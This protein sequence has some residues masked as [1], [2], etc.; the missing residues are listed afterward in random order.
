MA[1]LPLDEA[2]EQGL[3]FPIQA[4]RRTISGPK[5][6]R[7]AEVRNGEPLAVADNGPWF[8]AERARVA[9]RTAGHLEL[10][11]GGECGDAEREARP[12]EDA[13]GGIRRRVHRT[14]GGMNTTYNQAVFYGSSPTGVNLSQMF[15][16]PNVSTKFGGG[17]HAL[18]VTFSSAPTKLT[19]N[20]PDNSIGV[21][22]RVGYLGQISRYLS[23]G[24]S[25]QSRTKMGKFSNYAGLYAE[26]GGFDLPSNWVAGVAIKPIP[27]VDIALDVQG[28]R[29][30]EVKSI[31]NPMLPNLQTARLG[32]ATGAGFGWQD[33]T[34]VKMGV[35]FRSGHGLTWRG[36]YSCG[37][38]P[39]QPSEVVF[40]ILAPGV[41]EQ[42]VTGGLS[43]TFG[44]G[45]ALHLAVTKALSNSVT[46]PNP[47][48]VPNRQQ[49]KLTMNQWDLEFGYSIKFGRQ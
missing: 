28:I 20:G 25:Y 18:G 16:A 8:Q 31:A 4:R 26:Q 17:K 37:A 6:P 41:I 7:N 30:S 15:F 9:R 48:E 22:V 27:A 12:R 21:G 14:E 35:Q 36:G 46:G 3:S 19:D 40:N 38:N 44:N 23:V 11:V 34:T 1:P 42:H 24:A 43:K 32:D 10:A 33:M 47:L 49:V 29:Y 39:V 5:P 2:E 45:H 13:R